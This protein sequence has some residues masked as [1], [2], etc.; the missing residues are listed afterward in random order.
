[1]LINTELNA[2]VQHQI[3]RTDDKFVQWKVRRLLL[4]GL[5]ARDVSSRRDDSNFFLQI[6]P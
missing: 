5:R 1:M 3:D 4:L 6:P 2:F